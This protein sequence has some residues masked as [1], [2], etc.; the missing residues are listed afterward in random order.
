MEAIL[1]TKRIIEGL[2]VK[3]AIIGP[4]PRFNERAQG[5]Y[6]WQLIV[7]SKSRIDLLSIIEHLPAN[8][9]YDIDPSNLL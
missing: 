9:H 5:M 1:K 4:A 2:A 7:K 3:A 6:Q 8:T